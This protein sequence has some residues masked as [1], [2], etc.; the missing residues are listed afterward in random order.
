MS[1]GLSWGAGTV[2]EKEPSWRADPTPAETDTK[3][4]SIDTNGSILSSTVELV[5]DPQE[6]TADANDSPVEE[7]LDLDE[8]PE[9][10]IETVSKTRVYIGSRAIEPGHD[11]SQY[12]P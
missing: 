8:E 5:T 4:E 6:Q 1:D 9:P 10:R 2:W 7:I 12:H 11:L 3:E